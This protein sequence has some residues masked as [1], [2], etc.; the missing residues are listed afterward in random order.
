VWVGYAV[1]GLAFPLPWAL[2]GLLG[3][4]IILGFIWGVTGIPPTEAQSL[5][6]KGEAYRRYQERVSK[7]GPWPPRRDRNAPS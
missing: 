3:Q 7:F 6:S 4:A 2:F 5:R 1:Y